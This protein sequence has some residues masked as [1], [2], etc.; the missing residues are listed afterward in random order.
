MR[1]SDTPAAAAHTTH[2]NTA[3]K[4]THVPAESTQHTLS[5]GGGVG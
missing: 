2:S 1:H 3:K 5:G 4:N